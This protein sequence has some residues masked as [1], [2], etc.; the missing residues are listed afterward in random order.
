[1][2]LERYQ[3]FNVRHVHQIARRE[4][5]VKVSYGF[6]TQTLQ[7]AAARETVLSHSLSTPA[8]LLKSRSNVPRGT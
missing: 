1:M 3:G 6:L 7:A 8:S 2:T 5:G 4:H